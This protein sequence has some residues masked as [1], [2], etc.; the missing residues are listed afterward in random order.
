MSAYIV[1]CL[2]AIKWPGSV[3]AAP[4][5]LGLGRTA[6]AAV[7]LLT[8]ADVLLC[9]LASMRECV[10]I[11]HLCSLRREKLKSKMKNGGD[12]SFW[13]YL[14]RDLSPLAQTITHARRCRNPGKFKIKY[15][16]NVS[17]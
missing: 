12:L 3:Q 2:D 8:L 4:A 14:T 9:A 7:V 17:L 11:T 16:G 6:A 1:V 10:V 5:A 15:G 13:F